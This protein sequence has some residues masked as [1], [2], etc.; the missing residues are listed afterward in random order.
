LRSQGHVYAHRYP[1]WML[2]FEARL[3]RKRINREYQ[4]Q[5]TIILMA[6]ATAFTGGKKAGKTFTDFLRNFDD[7]END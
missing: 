1:L 4:T 7:G 3:A 5:A 2:W 6:S